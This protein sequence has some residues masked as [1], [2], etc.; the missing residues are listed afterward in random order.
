METMG[1][2]TSYRKLWQSY[3][4]TRFGIPRYAGFAILLVILA[5]QPGTDLPAAFENLVVTFFFLLVFRMMDDAW[6]FHSDRIDHPERTYLSPDNIRT[7][8]VGS[9]VVYALFQLVL[10]A[11]SLSWAVTIFGLALASNLLC[12][13]F[14][15]IRLV[16]A[17][18][19]LLKYPVLIWCLSGFSVSD[20]VLC[21]MA[22][23]FFMMVCVDLT[24]DRD[25]ISIRAILKLLFLLITGLLVT[26]PWTGSRHIWINA[27]FIILPA[28]FVMAFRHKA[29]RFAPA[30][31]Y[32]L[33]HLI[34]LTA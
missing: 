24:H 2:F 16:M 15:R 10:F 20:E 6:S 28:V 1:K 18:I 7:F 19:P 32:P 3:L 25:L 23:S 31:I 17:A 33:I 27:V 22:A 12:L 21:L 26:Q 4:A 34:L 5:A 30:V 11:W 8:A 29:L 9:L 13:A 14:Y